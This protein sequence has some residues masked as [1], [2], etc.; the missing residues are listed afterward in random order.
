MSLNWPPLKVAGFLKMRHRV[1]AFLWNNLRELADWL[2]WVWANIR[3]GFYGVNYSRVIA[4]LC[5][6]HPGCQSKAATKEEVLQR[7]LVPLCSVSFWQKH[8]HQRFPIPLD[9]PRFFRFLL[10]HENIE[11]NQDKN[12]LVGY[13]SCHNRTYFQRKAAASL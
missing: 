11:G 3:Y 4:S 12:V 9:V 13:H 2:L 10:P 1:E 7:L 5:Y 8:D 6:Q